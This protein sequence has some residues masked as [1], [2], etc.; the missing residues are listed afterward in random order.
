MCAPGRGRP[1][2]LAALPRRATT[3]RMQRA[4]PSSGLPL[5]LYVLVKFVTRY[6]PVQELLIGYKLHENNANGSWPPAPALT[7]PVRSLQR[8]RLCRP[9]LLHEASEPPV[10]APF[11]R[12]AASHRQRGCWTSLAA[13]ILPPA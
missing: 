10:T 13:S 1:T 9:R 6:N 11:P 7:V 8:K 3:Q 5:R 12:A 2:P 4:V